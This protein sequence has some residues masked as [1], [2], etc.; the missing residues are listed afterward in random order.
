MES[1]VCGL[2]PFCLSGCLSAS[3]YISL[4][5]CLSV[6]SAMFTHGT[7]PL[8]LGPFGL[9]QTHVHG[10]L[11]HHLLAI[12]GPCQSSQGP[13]L[14]GLRGGGMYSVRAVAR[15]R[16][17]PPWVAVVRH[18]RVRTLGRIRTVRRLWGKLG[19]WADGVRSRQV[20]SWWIL[21]R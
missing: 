5:L 15:D 11:Q 7:I 1:V 2:S 8:V 16:K 20:V 9:V 21:R 6:N 19:W 12:P 14:R 17:G 13:N 10:H 3:L 18:R 4:S